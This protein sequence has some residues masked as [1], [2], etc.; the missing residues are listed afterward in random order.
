MKDEWWLDS[1]TQTH[2]T[3]ND[4]GFT[5]LQKTKNVTLGSAGGDEIAVEGVGSYQV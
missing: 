2:S 4:E 3:N 5:S 1:G